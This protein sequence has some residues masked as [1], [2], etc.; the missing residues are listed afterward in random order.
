[1]E[2]QT[3]TESVAQDTGADAALPVQNDNETAV[4]QSTDKPSEST[5]GESED[6][7]PSIDEKLQSFAKGQ[8]IED[9]SQ[10][11][12]REQ[13]LLKIAYDNNAE[14]QRTR[15]K[16]S[17]LE[18]SLTDT[19]DEY[20]EQIAYSTGQDPEL[21]KRVQRVEVKEAVRDF[22]NAHPDARELE[23]DM[24]A[25]LVKRPHLA[26]DLEALYAV[27]KASNLDAVKSQGKKEALQSLAHKQT[28]AV[29]RGNAV[30]SSVNSQ[31]ITPQNVDQLVAQ[32]GQEWFRKNYDAINRAMAARN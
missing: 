30:S 32:N 25:E 24:I 26:G 13:K 2:E 10:L 18:K 17:E 11:S 20:A 14:Y 4:S 28:A 15:Q 21:L 1:M 29:P 12:E 22:F 27:V 3:I 8:G 5:Q 7:L 23:Q 6:S 31:S 16:A 19:S 9:V